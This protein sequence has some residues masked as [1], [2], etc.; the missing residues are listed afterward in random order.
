MAP[1]MYACGRKGEVKGY[2]EGVDIYAFGMAVTEMAT[3]EYPYSECRNIGQIF[4]CVSQGIK[5]QCLNQLTAT[6][7]DN[8]LDFIYK[9]ID[10]SPESR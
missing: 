3:G 2:G 7:S 8:L 10:S 4:R 1:E 6:R 5:P 9:C